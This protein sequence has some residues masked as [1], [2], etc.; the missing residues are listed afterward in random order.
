MDNRKIAALISILIAIAC[1]QFGG[2]VYGQ[3]GLYFGGGLGLI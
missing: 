1:Y 2:R 3:L